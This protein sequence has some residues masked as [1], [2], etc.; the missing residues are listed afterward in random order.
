MAKKK[1]GDGPRAVAVNRK[2]RHNYFITDTVEAGIML[3]GP[4]VKSLRLGSA[5]IGEAFASDRDGDLFLMNAH[6]PPYGPA[7]ALHADSPLRPRKLLLH[8]K[9]LANYVGHKNRTGITVV[10]LSIYFNDRG[11]AKVEL[12]IAKGKKMH[13]K[14]AAD[15]D[16]DWNRDKARLMRDK[17]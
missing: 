16:R 17:G 11:I 7:T 14:R 10:P 2:A 15:K 12:G 4:E 1:K 8:K 6:I 13:D 3:T 9:Q 5:S